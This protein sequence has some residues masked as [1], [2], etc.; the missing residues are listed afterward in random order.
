MANNPQK[1]IIGTTANP[2]RSSFM[3]CRTLKEPE[4]GDGPAKG[5]CAILFSKKDKE[6]YQ[7]VMAAIEAAGRKKF[8][9]KFST[10]SKRMKTPILDGDE[11]F[12]DPEYTVGEE[13]KGMWFIST[14]CYKVPQIVDRNGQRILDPDEVDEKMSSG[15]YFLF[16]VTFKPFSHD[17]NKGVRA[18]LNNLMFIKEGERLD[19]SASAEQDFADYAMDDNDDQDFDDNDDDDDDDDTPRRR[20]KKS[21]KTSRRR[22]R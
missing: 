4:E 21:P 22:R 6:T 20:S 13:A 5:S 3:F 19:G 15:N 2:A 18:E 17:S 9:D 11:L 12:E 1:V 10:K 16:S 8:G 14:S 7:K